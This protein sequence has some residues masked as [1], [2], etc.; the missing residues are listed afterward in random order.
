MTAFLRKQKSSYNKRYCYKNKIS[1]LKPSSLISHMGKFHS[2]TQA[3]RQTFFNCGVN[4]WGERVASPRKKEAGSRLACPASLALQS[5]TCRECE[6]HTAISVLLLESSGRFSQRTPR[7]SP[8]T[9]LLMFVHKF[10]RQARQV[11][12][13]GRSGRQASS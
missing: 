7:D 10:C 8:P 6:E 4:I 1:F 11:A 3:C 2:L 13:G 12:G 5:L 9:P